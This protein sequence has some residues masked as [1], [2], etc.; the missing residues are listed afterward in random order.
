ME[1]VP[2]IK[3]KL[4]NALP[5]VGIKD[6][7][8]MI[9]KYLP[10]HAEKFNSLLLLESRY[11]DIEQQMLQGVLSLEDIQLE[12]NK[13]RLDL[14]M[15]IDGL[16]EKDFDK[17]TEKEKSS[18]KSKTGKILYRIPDTMQV[19]EE[20]K[21]V[22]RVAFTEAVLLENIEVENMDEIK[23]IR[24]SEVMAAQI[25]DPNA[26]P[27]FRIR[28][29]SEEIQFVDEEYF[30]EWL[31]F[32]TPL[33]KGTFSLI[34]KVSVIE[35]KMGRERKRDIVMEEKVVITTDAVEEEAPFKSADYDFVPPSTAMLDR[36]VPANP[37]PQAPSTP[38]ASSTTTPSRPRINRKVLNSVA[39]VLL[40]VGV[41]LAAITGLNN[42][43]AG[44][45]I[46]VA[47]TGPPTRPAPIPP[48][49][50][51]IVV[52]HEPEVVAVEVV[53][54]TVTKYKE[55]LIAYAEEMATIKVNK[56]EQDTVLNKRIKAT[57]KEIQYLEYQEALLDSTSTEV[58]DYLNKYAGDSLNCLYCHQATELKSYK[59]GQDQLR[60]NGNIDSLLNYLEV[61]P[62]GHYKRPAIEA[63]QL[64]D[65]TTLLPIVLDS[66]M[67]S[68]KGLKLS[69]LS[70][71]A[72]YQ[73]KIT[74]D[75]RNKKQPISNTEKEKPL[76][77]LKEVINSPVL[78]PFEKSNLT[79]N[80]YLLHI[81]DAKKRK[82]VVSL[83][84]KRFPK[85]R[86]KNKL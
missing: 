31:F 30:T 37:F 44:S 60:T 15:L 70:G 63:I 46:D 18:K 35:M 68:H 16:E 47:M 51:D 29:F 54:T 33:L 61:Y 74:R 11:R 27:A 23:S 22:I 40:I 8:A 2:E 24:V 1:A 50:I 26:N 64:K 58:L 75:R 5:V 38:T 10:A 84:K 12:T 41:S 62:N 9:K 20:T 25:I 65:A 21:C 4:K 17:K 76:I 85:E 82:I 66:L 48:P 52:A 43:L 45:N 77:D 13:I 69:F 72:P 86:E 28:T 34:L 56:V 32:V 73:F 49:P 36:G 59:L 83:N 78:I 39:S 14:L 55:D 6:T 71:Q 42:F 81:I 67:W 80:D 53:P 79:T 19:N 57:K 7:F 3:Q